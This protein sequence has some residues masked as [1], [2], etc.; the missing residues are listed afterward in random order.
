MSLKFALLT[1]CLSISFSLLS[2]ENTAEAVPEQVASD[3]VGKVNKNTSKLEVGVDFDQQDPFVNEI[4]Q[5]GN[6][7]VFDCIGKYW[8]CTGETEYKVCKRN[9]N[10]AIAEY[11][12]NIKC[13][14]F[15]EFDSRDECYKNQ[16]RIT[17]SGDISRF[18]MHPLERK[19]T[20][21]F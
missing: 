14:N 9:R 13:G 6:Y 21:D 5:K 20:K 16:Q 2:Q 19:R 4:Y 12:K 3:E 7:L 15:A 10:E 17:H 18:C 8:V 11:S 1:F